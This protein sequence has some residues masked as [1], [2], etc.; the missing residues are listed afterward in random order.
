[1]TRYAHLQ[2][3]NVYDGQSVTT[4]TVIG[5]V[6]NTGNSSGSHLH[7]GHRVNGTSYCN[8]YPSCPNGDARQ[9]PQG[10]KPSPMYTNLG[11]KTMADYGCYQAPP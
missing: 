1:M 7:Y 8:K 9:S 3:D 4:Q 5:W 10:R 11:W 2:A 6:G